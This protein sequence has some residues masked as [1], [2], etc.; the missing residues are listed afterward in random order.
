MLC[1]KQGVKALKTHGKYEKHHCVQLRGVRIAVVFSDGAGYGNRTRL[2]G[3]GSRCTTDVLILHL[4]IL[5]RVHLF[6][7][8]A[9][10]FA[11]VLCRSGAKKFPRQFCRGNFF[12][13]SAIKLMIRYFIVMSSCQAGIA[14]TSKSAYQL[15]REL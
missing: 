7:H 14:Y 12:A 10:R 13:Y 11:T 4:H 1:A 15:L 2:L 5:S 8:P 3:L 9:A 6:Y